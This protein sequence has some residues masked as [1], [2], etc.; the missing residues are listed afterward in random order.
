MSR[1][2]LDYTNIV[3]SCNNIQTCGNSKGNEYD[4]DRFV[5]PLQSDCEERFSYDPDGHMKGDDYT[6]SLL[7]LNSYELKRARWSV[8]RTIINM[9][10]EDIR[11]VFC[12]N[13]EEY[14]PFSNVIF[15]FL[16]NMDE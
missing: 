10:N 14:L 16:K 5:S 6:I 7:N 12:N 3:A 13:E 11:L 2:S 8:Y 15:W 4:G 1:R 9:K